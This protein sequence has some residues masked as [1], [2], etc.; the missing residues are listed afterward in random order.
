[1]ITRVWMNLCARMRRCRAA[2]LAVL[3]V[4]AEWIPVSSLQAWSGATVNL[5][6]SQGAAG[7]V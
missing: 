1:M 2:L 7:N 6:L 4:T 5:S 3:G